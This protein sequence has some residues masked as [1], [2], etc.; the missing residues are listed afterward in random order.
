MTLV[1]LIFNQKN[2]GRLDSGFDSHGDHCAFCVCVCACSVWVG[3]DWDKQSPPI[4]YCTSTKLN[5]PRP[6]DRKSSQTKS[7]R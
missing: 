7:S 2:N 5:T 3:A 6:Y 1:H 4:L